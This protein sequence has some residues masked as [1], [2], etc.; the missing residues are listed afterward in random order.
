MLT[1]KYPNGFVFFLKL[2]LK[3]PEDIFAWK[4]QR[5]IFSLLQIAYTVQWAEVLSEEVF[6]I[7][8][9]TCIFTRYFLNFQSIFLD[10]KHEKIIGTNQGFFSF[11]SETFKL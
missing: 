10:A 11:I 8:Y 6:L 5:N 9:T 4:L 7:S 3:S 1:S 2:M